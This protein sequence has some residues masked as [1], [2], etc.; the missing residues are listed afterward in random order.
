MD[1]EGSGMA[2]HSEE[3]AW[4]GAVAAGLSPLPSIFFVGSA[5]AVVHLPVSLSAGSAFALDLRAH[6]RPQE[7]HGAQAAARS[8]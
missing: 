2:R 5:S 7:P 3:P 4:K 8:G 1:R 6:P